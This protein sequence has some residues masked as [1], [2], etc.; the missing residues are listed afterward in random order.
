MQGRRVG[1]GVVTGARALLLVLVLVL[2]LMLM[3][4]LVLLLGHSGGVKVGQG[5]QSGKQPPYHMPHSLM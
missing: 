2:V 5:R 3:L 4:V 1:V